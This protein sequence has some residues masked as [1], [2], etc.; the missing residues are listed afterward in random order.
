M[1]IKITF[2]ASAKKKPVKQKARGRDVWLYK[3]S[4][5]DISELN[6]EVIDVEGES[7]LSD[8]EVRAI[9]KQLL[10]LIGGAQRVSAGGVSAGGASAIVG[11]AF[12]GH[13][14]TVFHTS[15]GLAV[16]V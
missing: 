3:D 13:V 14:P 7:V 15:E 1:A 11:G 16:Y 9:Y 5:L 4:D 10:P 2:P 6:P 12:G 8:A